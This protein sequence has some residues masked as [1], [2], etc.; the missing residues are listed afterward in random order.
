MTLVQVDLFITRFK[1]HPNACWIWTGSKDKD[2]YG[3]FH[4][5]PNHQKAHRFSYELFKGAIGKDLLVCHKCDNPSCVN[6]KHLWLGTYHDN[7]K[8]MYNKGNEKP[9]YRNVTHCLNG[10]EFNKENTYKPPRSKTKRVCR[11]C[12]RIRNR[13][14]KKKLRG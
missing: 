2:G 11:E 1:V 10:H 12:Q 13:I 7:L 3:L 6:P 8:D 4:A 14:F 5:R 9:P